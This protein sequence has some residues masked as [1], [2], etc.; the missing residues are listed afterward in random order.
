MKEQT[1]RARR[2]AILMAGVVW[3][4]GWLNL[5]G[6]IVYAQYCTL[7]C[8]ASAPGNGTAGAAIAFSASATTYYCEGEPSFSWNFGDGSSGSGSSVTHTYTAPG[9]YSWTVTATLSDATASRG[10]SITITGGA[11]TVTG[12][13]AAS[14]DGS[15]FSS[16]G[17]V[18]AFGARLATTT[19]AA[20]SL[21]LPTTLAGS[22]VKIKDSAGTE[23]LAPLFFVSPG[24]INFQ[25]PPGTAE[26]TATMTVTSGDG[27][28]AVGTAQIA[29]VAPGLFTANADGKG[30]P[31]GYVLR[32]RADN[33]QSVEPLAR[34]DTAQNRF[35]A[36]PIDMGTG[37]DQ[38]FV[39]LFGTGVRF[40]SSL[41]A[42][43][44]RV[45]GENATVLFVGPQGDFVGLDQLNVQLPRT[46]VG[47][48][49]V[50]WTLTV[51]GKTANNVLLNF[52]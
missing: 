8:S 13:S 18:A 5:S 39:I 16:E 41:S 36:V 23:R 45:G 12:V 4:L 10:G 14:Y 9:T 29:S 33:S 44:V 40:R 35:V 48:G 51:D 15:S 11:S 21:P 24:Q 26:G 7:T 30:V 52:R 6:G 34:F 28:L 2:L 27:A 47:R 1:K 25:I 38:V 20:T 32:I 46:L 37:A 50:E 22:T 17:I 3:S 42:V 31:A 43:S 49:E 19:Q